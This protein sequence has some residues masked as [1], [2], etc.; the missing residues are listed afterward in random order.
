MLRQQAGT[1]SLLAPMSIFSLFCLLN[2]D[3]IWAHTHTGGCK[4]L[5]QLISFRRLF[6]SSSFE[7]SAKKRNNLLV[8]AYFLEALIKL[9][10]SLIHYIFVMCLLL[11]HNTRDMHLCES[12]RAFWTSWLLAVRKTIITKILLGTPFPF[13]SFSSLQWFSIEI[14][15][16]QQ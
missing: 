11:V 7:E 2:S 3:F 8:S 5:S 12:V 6:S 14:F 10:H 1:Y 15:F 4:P 9:H 13:R 16:R